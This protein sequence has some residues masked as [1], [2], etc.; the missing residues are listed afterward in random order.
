MVF[1]VKCKREY[2]LVLGRFKSNVF[3][4]RVRVMDLVFN[5]TFNNISVIRW[6]SVLLVEETEVSGEYWSRITTISVWKK[7]YV[8]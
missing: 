6:W 5:A 8:Y 4:S 1:L 3:W 7:K 2:Y